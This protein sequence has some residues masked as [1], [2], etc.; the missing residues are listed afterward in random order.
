VLRVCSDLTPFYRAA[1]VNTA[2]LD[3]FDPYTDHV[4]DHK[5]GQRPKEPYG[6]PVTFQPSELL[7]ALEDAIARHKAALSLKDTLE[8][9]RAQLMILTPRRR[10]VFEVIVRG[11][12]W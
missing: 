5:N 11:K 4:D 9:L 2:S 8:A 1:G 10:Q 12:A 3:R 7:K 6:W